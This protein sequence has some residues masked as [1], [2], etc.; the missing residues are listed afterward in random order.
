M[1]ENTKFSPATWIPLGSAVVVCVSILAGW[2][3]LDERL[4][5]SDAKQAAQ[6][7]DMKAEF[8]GVKYRLERVEDSVADR[9]T[10]DRISA[11]RDLLEV[12]NIGKGIIV[13]PFRRD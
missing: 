1:P 8:Q 12:S 7:A 11:W 10:F 2:N 13:P 4:D 5:T 6:A 3:W 9:V